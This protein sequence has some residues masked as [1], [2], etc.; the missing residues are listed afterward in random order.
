MMEHGVASFD[1]FYRQSKDPCF[2]AVVA[3]LGDVEAAA[4]ALD[5]AMVRACG[6]WGRLSSHPNPEAWVVRTAINFY[7]SWWRRRQRSARLT[8]ARDAAGGTPEPFDESL[9]QALRQLPR[10]QREVV[11]LRVL[12]DQDTATTAQQLGIAP[13]TVTAHLHRALTQLRLAMTMREDM[14]ESHDLR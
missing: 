8:S 3:A 13:G 2:R 12:L 10:R 7:R 4:E 6:R 11:A 9:L 14:E 1:A 5:E